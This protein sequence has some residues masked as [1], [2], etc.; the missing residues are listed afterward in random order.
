MNN[1]HSTR[2]RIFNIH[3][4]TLNVKVKWIMNEYK[5][6][7][8]FIKKLSRR[9]YRMRWHHWIQTSPHTHTHIR[10]QT[11]MHWNTHTYTSRSS[12]VSKW[13]T[14]SLSYCRNRS[15][16]LTWRRWNISGI[17][18]VRHCSPPFIWCIASYLSPSLHSPLHLSIEKRKSEIIF[19]VAPRVPLAIYLSMNISS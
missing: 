10:T 1:V 5:I 14:P 4:L 6:R 3:T 15:Y 9:T 19:S 18:T 12:S 17:S 13:C 7:N 11:H 8:D 16:V 2:K